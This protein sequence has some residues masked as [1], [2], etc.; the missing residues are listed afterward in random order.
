MLIGKYSRRHNCQ[1]AFQIPKHKTGP[2]IAILTFSIYEN[3]NL[4]TTVFNEIQHQ[5]AVLL[6]KER[7]AIHKNGGYIYI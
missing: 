1:E 4:S 3:N 5:G 7:F 6:R 2:F